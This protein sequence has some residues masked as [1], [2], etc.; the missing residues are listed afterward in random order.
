MNV[1][2]QTLIIPIK[3]SFQS[4]QRRISCGFWNIIH[5]Y[6]SYTLLN[7]NKYLLFSLQVSLK[8][9]KV[10]YSLF[11]FYTLKFYRVSTNW[12][13][14]GDV[15]RVLYYFDFCVGMFH[16]GYVVLYVTVASSTQVIYI[17]IYICICIISGISRIV[18]NNDNKGKQFAVFKNALHI[19]VS[20]CVCVWVY[21]YLCVS[22]FVCG[23][24]ETG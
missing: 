7:C 11:R 22:V 19:A 10:L 15:F 6:Y 8:A 2:L 24:R 5:V 21:S 4:N 13:Q 18:L 9:A 14:I 16:Y 23:V 12:T 1:D 3:L 17:Y 20:L